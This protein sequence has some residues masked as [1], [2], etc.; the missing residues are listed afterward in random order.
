MRAVHSASTV[1]QTTANRALYTQQFR[2]GRMAPSPTRVLGKQT[3]N[4]VKRYQ[5][6]HDILGD[7]QEG[8]GRGPAPSDRRRHRP[9][10]D[11]GACSACSPDADDQNGTQF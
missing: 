10:R 4:S 1:V 5:D 6:L 7:H 3:R 11:E 8:G 9:V 2:R